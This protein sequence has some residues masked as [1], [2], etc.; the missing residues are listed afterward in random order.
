MKG[1]D[2]YEL[3]VPIFLLGLFVLALFGV[4]KFKGNLIK[5]PLL[6]VESGNEIITSEDSL[7][8]KGTTEKNVSKLLI[9]G[10]KV[11]PDSAGNFT[12]NVPLV[13]GQNQIK[14]VAYNYEMN[15]SV[16]EVNVTKE[17][18]SESVLGSNSEQSQSVEP[19]TQVTEMSNSG[20][21]ENIAVLGISILVTLL[22]FNYDL[23]KSKNKHNL[24]LQ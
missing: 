7:T 24:A 6:T 3:F 10:S 19:S 21:T 15:K 14:V 22:A 1:S 16:R 4:Y 8:V 11:E 23:K 2:W 18:K 17:T 13:S 12:A 9:N 20:P 5:A